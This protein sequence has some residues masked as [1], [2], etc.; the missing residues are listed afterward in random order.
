MV[1]LFLYSFSLFFFLKNNKIVIF[2]GKIIFSLDFI[3]YF[4]LCVRLFCPYTC[5]FGASRGQKRTSHL[6]ELQLWAALW[7][8]CKSLGLRS[9][10]NC[11][12]I[13][14]LGQKKI[15]FKEY[16]L[17]INRNVFYLPFIFEC[18]ISLIISLIIVGSIGNLTLLPLKVLSFQWTQRR[19]Q[20]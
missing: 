17:F 16:M 13:F 3:F 19:K 4:I 20:L 18:A 1:F 7:V 10:L 15:F 8:L 11:W 6:L 12:A 5:M 9:V 2:W 14:S